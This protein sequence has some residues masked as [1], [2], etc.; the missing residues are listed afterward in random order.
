[1]YY[2][3]FRDKVKQVNRFFSSLNLVDTEK[4]HIMFQ[5]KYCRSPRQ[6]NSPEFV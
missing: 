2:N 5:L 4:K 1:M 3:I 6:I